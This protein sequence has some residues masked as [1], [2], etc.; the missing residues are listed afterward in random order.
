MDRG[1]SETW[2][3]ED[4]MLKCSGKSIGVMERADNMKT[5]AH[6]EWRHM[7]AGGNSEFLA[8][9]DAIPFGNRLPKGLEIQML[10]QTG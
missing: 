3:V 7:E 6:V 10:D 1:H 5:F 9:S 2:W 8:W 4:G